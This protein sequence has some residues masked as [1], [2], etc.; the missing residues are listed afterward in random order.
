[1]I[2]I[3]YNVCGFLLICG[4]SLGFKIQ[5]NAGLTR[6]WG[7]HLGSTTCMY[8]MKN[9]GKFKNLWI[10]A[11]VVRD[12]GIIFERSKMFEKVWRNSFLKS[13]QKS[14]FYNISYFNR[15]QNNFFQTCSNL[16]AVF[17]TKIS[18]DYFVEID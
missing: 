5:N 17:K 11:D 15:V 10:C 6:H 4:W 2:L 13:A 16:L 8:S 1:M 12:I 7:D 9:V 3:T 18:T 14:L